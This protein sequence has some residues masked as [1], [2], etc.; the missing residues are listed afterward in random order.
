MLFGWPEADGVGLALG[1]DL[2]V[3]ELLDDLRRRQLAEVD[4]D[5]GVHA[6]PPSCRGTLRLN[7]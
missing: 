5:E 3:I 2:L 4:G 1:E 6:L 7:G